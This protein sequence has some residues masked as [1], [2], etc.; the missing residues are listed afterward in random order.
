MLVKTK[1]TEFGSLNSPSRIGNEF[2]EVDQTRRNSAT[3][4]LDGESRN[5]AWRITEE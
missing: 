2:R 5:A 1:Q 4:T 3:M